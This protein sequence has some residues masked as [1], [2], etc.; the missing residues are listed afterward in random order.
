MRTEKELRVG[1]NVRILI[2]TV[3]LVQVLLHDCFEAVIVGGQ[4]SHTAP[5]S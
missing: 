2:A 3:V 1:L 5:M 4:A